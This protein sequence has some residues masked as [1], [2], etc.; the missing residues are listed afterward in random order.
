METFFLKRNVFLF[1]SLP[2]EALVGPGR[3]TPS[4]ESQ[5][6][7][8]SSWKAILLSVHLLLVLTCELLEGKMVFYSFL[9]SWLITCSQ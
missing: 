5:A 1:K 9:Y 8:H 3:D 2:F 4:L 7:E 6:S